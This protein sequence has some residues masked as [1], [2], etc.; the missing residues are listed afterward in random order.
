MTKR[1]LTNDAEIKVFDHELNKKRTLKFTTKDDWGFIGDD[2]DNTV[3]ELVVTKDRLPLTKLKHIFNGDSYLANYDTAVHEQRIDDDG[4]VHTWVDNG[5]K[6]YHN[7][8]DPSLAQRYSLEQVIENGKDLLALPDYHFLADPKVNEPAYLIDNE[9]DQSSGPIVPTTKKAVANL[10]RAVKNQEVDLTVSPDSEVHFAGTLPTGSLENKSKLTLGDKTGAQDVKLDNSDISWSGGRLSNVSFKDCQTK[11]PIAAAGESVTSGYLSDTDLNHVKLTDQND[12]KNSVIDY[13]QLSKSKIAGSL[14]KG[15]KFEDADLKNALTWLNLDSAIYNTKLHNSRL[16]DRKLS[17]AGYA[18][19]WPN[20]NHPTTEQE[21]RATV[22]EGCDF[23]NVQ[24]VQSEDTGSTL[25]NVKMK[26]AFVNEWLIGKDSEIVAKN[27]SRPA[28]VGKLI[29]DHNKLNF[30]KHPVTFNMDIWHS[31]AAE[32]G[33]ELPKDKE[34]NDDN[35]TKESNAVALNS[36]SPQVSRLALAT[37]GHYSFGDIDDV[38]SNLG[39]VIGEDG[40]QSLSYDA[41][42][43]ANAKKLQAQATN[44]KPKATDKVASDEPEL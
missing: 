41:K 4:R 10:R 38:F 22:L 14:L 42:A 11:K 15:G 39:A 44:Q 18:E 1:Y 31:E 3:T 6:I 2:K 32:N 33:L 13:S 8:S 28:I 5:N 29:M 40:G 12:I 19:A 26:N 20:A 17:M 34:Y 27:I 21:Q 30:S 23:D 16:E 24:L 35:I 37:R 25:K 9:T 36:N 7:V 43:K